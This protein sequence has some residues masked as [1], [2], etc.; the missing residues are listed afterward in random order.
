MS[1]VAISIA[2]H[3]ILLTAIWWSWNLIGVEVTTGVVEEVLVMVEARLVSDIL[4][5][6]FVLWERVCSATTN[7]I[8]DS[9]RIYI[10]ILLQLWYNF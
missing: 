3:G 4:D 9:K 10:F 1:M 7:L 8:R 6:V 2:F 5:F